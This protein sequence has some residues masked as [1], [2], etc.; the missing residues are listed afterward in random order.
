MELVGTISQIKL[1]A[2]NF[3]KQNTFADNVLKVDSNLLNRQA[4]W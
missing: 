1:P 2:I 4:I 3:L